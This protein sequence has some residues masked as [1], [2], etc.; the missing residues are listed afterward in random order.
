MIPQY[1]YCMR[2]AKREEIGGNGI[3]VNSEAE[4]GGGRGVASVWIE[5]R[6]S[7]QP[8]PFLFDARST[9]SDKLCEVVMLVHLVSIIK[10][11]VFT[12]QLLLLVLPQI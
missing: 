12:L 9:N 6:Q 5:R 3:G 2:L 8:L 11:V 10:L 7:Q 1:L 4:G